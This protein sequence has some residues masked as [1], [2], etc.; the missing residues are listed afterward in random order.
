MIRVQKKIRHKILCYLWSNGIGGGG[1]GGGERGG[2]G[3]GMGIG[4]EVGMGR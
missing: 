1:G 4:G 3:G 2:G